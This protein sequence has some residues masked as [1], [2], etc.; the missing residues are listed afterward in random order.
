[1]TEW[2]KSVD[3]RK[4]PSGSAEYFYLDFGDLF[5]SSITLELPAHLHRIRDI[6]T[7]WNEELTSSE[8]SS[9]N[10]IATSETDPEF[11]VF[12]KAVFAVSE[13]FAFDGVTIKAI[14]H[15]H[16]NGK[17]QANQNVSGGFTES[18]G[19][20]WLDSHRLVLYQKTH[21]DEKKEK[22]FPDRIKKEILSLVNSC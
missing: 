14:E 5:Q 16:S 15:L 4:I 21:L 22:V 7:L 10:K 8:Y 2:L 1:L 17:K 3:R 6:G 12:Q 19:F 11:Y 9:L 13:K 18:I 20:I